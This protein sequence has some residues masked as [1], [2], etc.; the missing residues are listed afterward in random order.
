[1]VTEFP[2]VQRLEDCAVLSN[3]RCGCTFLVH[4]VLCFSCCSVAGLGS[5]PSSQDSS[6]G[7]A[8]L[9]DV[10]DTEPA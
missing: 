8:L 4:V 1:M 2:P 7:A 10:L 6:G 3:T 5:E 9:R